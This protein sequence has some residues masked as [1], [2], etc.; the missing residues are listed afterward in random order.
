MFDPEYDWMMTSAPQKYAKNRVVTQTR[1]KGLGGTSAMN[2]LAWLKP[3]KVDLDSIEKLGNP[4][5]NWQ[6]YLKYSKKPE[7]FHEP[8]GP[9][10]NSSLRTLLMILAMKAQYQSHSPQ[11]LLESNI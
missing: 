6:N 5:W 10:R 2:C 3:H 8:T 11:F 7:R 4:G 1:G 9:V